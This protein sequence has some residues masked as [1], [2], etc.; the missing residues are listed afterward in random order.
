MK[1]IYIMVIQE[2]ILFFLALSDVWGDINK[3]KGKYVIIITIGVGVN[4]CAVL[5]KV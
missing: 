3:Y 4:M 5:Y 1:G 2:L